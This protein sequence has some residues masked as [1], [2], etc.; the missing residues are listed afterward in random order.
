MAVMKL[1]KRALGG[2]SG[3]ADAVPLDVLCGVSGR[4]LFSA[5][6][7]PLECWAAFSPLVC[8]TLQLHI[9]SHDLALAVGNPSGRI[10]S[11]GRCPR[12]HLSSILGDCPFRTLISTLCL[13][14]GAETIKALSHTQREHLQLL[15]FAAKSESCA[16]T[17]SLLFA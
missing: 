13:L 9:P 1:H 5:P 14:A 6:S 16:P 12:T 8:L 3:I 17:L 2:R 7:T 15:P 11:H 4:A 10:R